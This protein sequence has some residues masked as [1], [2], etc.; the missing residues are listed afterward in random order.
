[1]CSRF[2]GTAALEEY[3]GIAGNGILSRFVI[4]LDYDRSRVILEP[5]SL[6]DEGLPADHTGFGVRIRGGELVVKQ[7]LEGSPADMAGLRE[8]DVLV[9]LEGTPVG[10]ESLDRLK[11]LLPHSPGRRLE[12]VVRREGEEMEMELTSAEL[13]PLD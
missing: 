1:M 3:D 13:L 11:S 9:S 5:S 8:G 7:V 10:P 12:A 6:F 4:W 2:S